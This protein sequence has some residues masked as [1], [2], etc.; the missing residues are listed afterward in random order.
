MSKYVTPPTKVTESG[1]LVK[2]YPSPGDWKL[3]KNPVLFFDR[4]VFQG[5]V[6]VRNPE[7]DFDP[8]IK[9]FNDGWILYIHDYVNAGL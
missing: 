6:V 4:G 2:R 9:E 8:F 5:A 7:T 3:A 1:N